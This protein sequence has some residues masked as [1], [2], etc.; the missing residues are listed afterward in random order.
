MKLSTKSGWVKDKY[1]E[2]LKAIIENQGV[3]INNLDSRNHELMGEVQ[4][5]TEAL[6]KIASKDDK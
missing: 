5:L 6:I 3:Q 2:T 1:V 4:K